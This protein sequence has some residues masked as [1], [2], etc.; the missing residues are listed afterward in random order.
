MFVYR[1]A[2]KNHIKDLSGTGALIYGG[3]WNLKGISLVY[4]SE[5]RALAL[6]EL[7]VNVPFSSMPGKMYMATIEIKNNIRPQKTV[8]TD[9]PKNWRKFPAP[10][11][12]AE[13][14][15]KWVASKE[16]LALRVPSAVVPQESNILIN[17]SHPDMP[18]VAIVEVE[19]FKLDDRLVNG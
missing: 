8:P 2:K 18:H 4:S 14:G 17:P 3:R 7:L 5:S 11:K 19:A 12:L 9:L 13:I 16:S 6:V 15:S 10:S 1:I